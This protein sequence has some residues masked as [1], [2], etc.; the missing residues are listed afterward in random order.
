MTEEESKFYLAEL[1][2]AI[3]EE[4]FHT[5]RCFRILITFLSEKLN[6][7]QAGW[8]KNSRIKDNTDIIPKSLYPTPHPFYETISFFIR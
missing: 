1:V 8:N 5:T 6:F 4:N 2:L 3:E 7:L